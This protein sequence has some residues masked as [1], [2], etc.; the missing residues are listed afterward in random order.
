MFYFFSKL[1]IISILRMRSV[2]KD[3]EAR[4]LHADSWLLTPGFACP[5]RAVTLA[6]CPIIKYHYLWSYFQLCGRMCWGRESLMKLLF[7][8]TGNTC[9]SPMA[10]ALASHIF[11]PDIVIESAGIDAFEGEAA[12]PPAVA[13]MRTRGIDLSGHCAR[14][15]TPEMMEAADM[16][17]AMTTAQRALV[18]RLSP[19]LAD[20]VYLLSEMAV[21][22]DVAANISDPWGGGMDRYEECAA[23]LE[24]CLLSMVQNSPPSEFSNSP[25]SEFSNFED[26]E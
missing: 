6:F 26:E 23:L 22:E 21:L 10:A 11:G 4:I 2:N 17:V 8:C 5:A 25:P 9:R 19:G 20:K 14:R 15:L 12:S 1:D 7:V 3:A 24:R 18:L 16:I 13:V